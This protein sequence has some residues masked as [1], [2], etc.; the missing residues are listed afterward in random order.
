[1]TNIRTALIAAGILGVSIAA[2]PL[3]AQAQDCDA[4]IGEID[5]RLKTADL[6]DEEKEKVMQ[7]RDEGQGENTRAG[8]DCT[9]TLQEALD[10][11]NK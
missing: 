8:G 3:V 5:E 4:M 2:T 10:I 9:S 7:I 6:T 11:L 1:M